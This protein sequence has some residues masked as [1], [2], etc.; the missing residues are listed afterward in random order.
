MRDY[1]RLTGK[2]DP[3]KWS[4]EISKVKVSLYQAAPHDLYI[5]LI[6]QSFGEFVYEVE[7]EGN[8][9]NLFE[10]KIIK[11]LRDKKLDELAYNYRQSR[12]RKLM[13]LDRDIVRQI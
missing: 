13:V 8:M 5:T 6:G 12:K 2:K 1:P 4:D 7:T 11:D 3:L 10:Y 9:V